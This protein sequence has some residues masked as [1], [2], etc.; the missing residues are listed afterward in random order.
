MTDILKGSLAPLTE[1]AWSE[2]KDAAKQTLKPLLSARKIVDFEGPKGWDFSAVNLGRLDVPKKSSGKSVGYGMRKVL[3]LIEARILFKL[4]LWELDNI[5]RGAA[6]PDLGPLE[7]AAKALALFED[8][9]IYKGLKDGQIDGIIPSA[10]QKAL[11]L[12]AN[13]Q[14]YAKVVAQGID[15]MRADG[16]GGP[17]ALVLSPA[18]YQV[19][20]QAV[21]PGYPVRR[22]LEKLLGGDD[23]IMRSGALDGGVLLSTRGGDFEM[24]VGADLSIGYSSHDSE[25]VH[26]FLTESFTFRVLEPAAAVE[27]KP[28]K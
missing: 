5:S 13:A 14:E 2:I 16:I 7:E 15:A 23:L 20:M 10:S 4:N 18:A 1:E 11:K 25:E 26:L 9:A 12:P 24:T 3:P 27:L 6:D 8:N 19:V 21:G 28:A 22:G 17:Y